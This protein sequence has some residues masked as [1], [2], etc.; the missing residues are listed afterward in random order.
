MK[1]WQLARLIPTAGIDSEKEAEA[2]ATSALLAV[3]TIVRPFSKA[4][5]DPLGASRANNALVEAYVEVQFD[6]AGQQIR[7]DGLIRVTHGNKPPWIALVEVKTGDNKLIA[8]QVNLYWDYARLNGYDAVITISS[9][10]PSALGVHPTAGLKVRSNAR[11]PVYHFSWAQLLTE[12][13]TQ[14][15]YRGVDDIEQAWIL[16][17]LIRYL[18]HRASGALQFTDMGPS[19]VEVRGAAR[20]GTLKPKNPNT[21]EVVERWDELL[22]YAALR[23]SSEI[24]E[25]V[26]VVLTNG[27]KIDP[28]TRS[29]E[30]AAALAERGVLTGALRVPNTAGDI[31][32]EADLRSQQLTAKVNVDAPRDRGARARVSWLLGQLDD[33]PDRSVIETWPRNARAASAT[34]NIALVRDDRALLL[35]GDCK[36]P[37]RFRTILRAPMGVARKT[38]TKATGFV[39]SLLGLVNEFYES[40]VQNVT[41]WQ[42][43]APRRQPLVVAEEPS[44]VKGSLSQPPAEFVTGDGDGTEPAGLTEFVVKSFGEEGAP[45]VEPRDDTAIAVPTTLRLTE[46]VT[47]PDGTLH[48]AY[49]TAGAPIYGDLT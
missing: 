33:A 24:G 5:L 39:D 29:T 48:L 15:S 4:L 22:Q 32:L 23:L 12:A 19:W 35:A 1:E 10:I 20:D 25:K 49:E 16:G 7:P 41:P 34:V 26:E 8:D 18:K 9:E 38:G 40:V 28:S 13:I 17:E 45:V 42:P 3:L 31:E 30:L 47:Y 46:S 11:V 37:A 43:Q 44:S 27:K 14:M 21:L 36:D 2:R 6:H